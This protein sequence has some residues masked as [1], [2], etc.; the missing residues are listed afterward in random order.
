MFIQFAEFRCRNIKYSI[1]AK[2]KWKEAKTRINKDNKNT[3]QIVKEIFQGKGIEFESKSGKVVGWD[4]IENETKIIHGNL[5][6]IKKY[7]DVV[8][9]T[10]NKFVKKYLEDHKKEHIDSLNSLVVKTINEEAEHRYK[11]E[12]ETIKLDLER[13]IIDMTGESELQGPISKSL[14][15]GGKYV[16]KIRVNKKELGK[17]ILED[18]VNIL[19]SRYD[20][21]N[22]KSRRFNENTI[23]QD[24]YSFIGHPD[25]TNE[26]KKF[27]T[28]IIE[29]LNRT[30]EDCWKE[31]EP[32]KESKNQKFHKDLYNLEDKVIVESDKNVGYCLFTLEQICLLYNKTNEEQGFVPIE[33]TD[34]Q[35]RN[36]ILKQKMDLIP[37]IPNWVS[38][39]I[40]GKQ[41]LNFGK[42][43]GGIGFLRI[44][45]KIHK[46]NAP[47]IKNFHEL[48]CRTIKSSNNDPVN[49]VA[50]IVGSVTKILLKHFKQYMIKKH[51]FHPAVPSCEEGFK[52]LNEKSKTYIW[53]ETL[54]A[55]ADIKNLYPSLDIKTVLSAHKKAM[56]IIKTD[57]KSAMFILNSLHIIMLN[58]IFRQPS[59]HFQSGDPTKK[60]SVNGF[61]IGCLAAA[62]S[63]DLTLLVSEDE[64][65][66]KLTEE[67]LMKNVALY[68]RYMDDLKLILIGKIDDILRAMHIIVTGYPSCLTLKI[69]ITFFINEFLDMW[70]YI[71]PPESKL[72]IILQ[73]K[74]NCLYD[75]TKEN[76]NTTTTYKNA[77]LY[78]YAHR[79]TG[80]TNV[81]RDYKHQYKI[82]QII[83]KKNGREPEA[84]KN[85]LRQVRNKQNRKSKIKQKSKKEIFK[86]SGGKIVY[87]EETN[88]HLFVGRLLRKGNPTETFRTPILVPG[89]KM[90][91]FIYTKYQFERKVKEKYQQERDKN[92]NV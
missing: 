10:K 48:T 32:N 3:N 65:L 68:C 63:S 7:E 67:N 13:S 33:I 88:S 16:P 49:A 21:E 80:R 1:K 14:E 42:T 59:G 25:L 66:E 89:K 2:E 6:I 61:A 69:K 15:V 56:D 20:K 72:Q 57:P 77:A 9:S 53:S 79:M 50:S 84:F 85:I 83:F 86:L 17:N 52:K 22:N 60:N 81:V 43:Q 73:R 82:N 39:N 28:N 40:T 30:I 90:R 27:L 54:N 64:I 36:R 12:E 51:G 58:N 23:F 35:Y 44:M 11:T 8:N 70:S 4:D 87:D 26:D 34:E 24:I 19:N 55:K 71:Y 78:S 38:A 31:Y 46:L 62:Q 45:P 74:K 47:S 18:V 5:N 91:S 75:I 76:S 92:G 41:K 37:V 29:S